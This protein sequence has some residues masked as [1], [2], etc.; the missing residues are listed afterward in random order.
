MRL[1]FSLEL[2]AFFSDFIIME[3]DILYIYFHYYNY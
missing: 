1:Q 2:L 3:I